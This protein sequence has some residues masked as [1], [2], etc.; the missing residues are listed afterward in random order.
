MGLGLEYEYLVDGEEYETAIDQV[1]MQGCPG[2]IGKSTQER[3][4]SKSTKKYRMS[5]AI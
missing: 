2:C 4:W 5:D 1:E 3:P